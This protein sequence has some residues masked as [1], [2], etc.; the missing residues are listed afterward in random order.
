MKVPEFVDRA[1]NA[2][3]AVAVLALAAVAVRR[4]AAVADTALPRVDGAAP[5][6]TESNWHEILDAGMVLGDRNAPV[7][8]AIFDD[9]ECPFCKRFHEAVMPAISARYGDTVATVLI[10]FPIAR[11]RFAARA[12]QALECADRSGRAGEF[13]TIVFS[14]QDSLGLI[15]W[16]TLARW[17]GI[18]DTLRFIRCTHG[19]EQPARI[20]SG[21]VLG[22]KIGIEGT[23]T[24]LVNGLRFGTPPSVEKLTRIID[25]ILSSR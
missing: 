14:K 6:T 12:A 24:V 17:A 20:A 22:R 19:E 9:L 7:H 16:G 5:P 4:E 3:I 23:P 15:G 8:L 11:H 13:L 18:S 10:H 21:L 1:L 2:I 25:S